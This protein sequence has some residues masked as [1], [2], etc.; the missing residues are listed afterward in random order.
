MD[1]T[2]NTINF[3]ANNILTVNKTLKNGTKN[4]IDVFLLKYGEDDCFVKYCINAI[5]NNPNF[6]NKKHQDLKLFLKDFLNVNTREGDYFIAIKNN[7]QIVGAA[8]TY[9]YDS[10]PLKSIKQA[11]NANKPIIGHFIPTTM[12]DKFININ[13]D[14]TTIYS[15]NTSI[16]NKAKQDGSQI[17]EWDGNKNKSFHLYNKTEIKKILP[18]LRYITQLFK[19]KEAKN[20]N[21]FDFLNINFED[22]ILY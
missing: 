8:Q 3:K 20:I 21:L 5:R 14:K 18:R 12:V 9:Q 15:L 11:T 17:I 2:T 16:I 10:T 1:L 19:S 22:R 6:I 4:T 13:Q 7:E